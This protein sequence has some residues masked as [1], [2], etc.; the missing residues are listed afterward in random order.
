MITDTEIKE[1]RKIL[2]KSINPI[3]LFDDDPDGLC[4]F[5]ILR[6]YTQE[7]KGIAIKGKLDEDFAERLKYMGGDLIVIVDVPVLDQEFVDQVSLPIL[8]IDHHEPLNLE[9]NI[10]YYNPRKENDEDNRSTSYWAYQITKKD[11]WLAMIGVVSDWSIPDFTDKFNKKYPGLLPKDIKDPGEAIFDT[12]LG[13][14][15]RI[16]GFT[17]KG[18]NDVRKSCLRILT[19]IESPNEILKQ[20]TPQGKYI[21][22]HY[23]KMNKHYEALSKEALSTEENGKVLIFTYPSIQHS[24]TGILANELKYHHPDKVVLIGR[25]KDDAVIMS[26]RSDQKIELPPIIEKSLKGLNG[27]GGGHRYA[28]G[29]WV[30]NDDFSKFIKR[31]KRYVNKA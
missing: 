27:R 21:Y 20:E 15:I 23:E 8:Y 11:L 19:R 16:F 3:Y 30:H 25:V 13:K 7:G 22:R 28:C 4:S 12:E 6:N 14:L 24:F 1:I 2:K 29:G 17:L 26:I 5:L 18:K 9:G 31:F 10:H